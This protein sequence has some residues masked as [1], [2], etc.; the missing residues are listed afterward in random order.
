MRSQ[1]YFG[2]IANLGACA[3]LKPAKDEYLSEKE[4]TEVGL[5]AAGAVNEVT[6]G[7]A[8]FAAVDVVGD[9]AGS[10]FGPC[11]GGDMG[12]YRHAWMCPER[13]ICGQGFDAK[14]IK[15]GV[16]QPA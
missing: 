11:V 2:G 14:H 15:R 9:D 5:V 6:K 8:R 1:G 7:K 12:G 3:G 4:A 10:T 16:A 13:M